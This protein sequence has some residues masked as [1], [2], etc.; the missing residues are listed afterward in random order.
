MTLPK[1]FLDSAVKG[2]FVV[3]RDGREVPADVY[4]DVFDAASRVIP[5][6]E[7]QLAFKAEHICGPNYWVALSPIL[8]R[9]AGTCL[10]DLV[11]RDLLPLVVAPRRGCVLRYRRR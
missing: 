5:T 2:R 8:A 3:L 1:A 4:T 11:D 6:L 10:H 9:L 7:Y